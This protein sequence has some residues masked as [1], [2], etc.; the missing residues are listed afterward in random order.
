[1]CPS[2]ALSYT[3]DG[4]THQDQ[5]RKPAVT[6]FPNVPLCILGGI[7]L[8]DPTDATTESEEHYTL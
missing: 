4:V 2:G 3:K 7:K 8:N 6:I 1:M 5:N